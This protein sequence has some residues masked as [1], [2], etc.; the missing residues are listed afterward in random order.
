MGSHWQGHGS[1]LAKVAMRVTQFPLCVL[2]LLVLVLDEIE[3][4]LEL[5]LATK[6]L[7]TLLFWSP[8]PVH[9]Q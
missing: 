7:A 1:H 6:G 5:S 9:K 4:L 8:K 2:E 3:H